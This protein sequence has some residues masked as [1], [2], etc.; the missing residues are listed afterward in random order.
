MRRT[1]PLRRVRRGATARPTHPTRPAGQRTPQTT[2]RRGCRPPADLAPCAKDPRFDASAGGRQPGLPTPPA[3]PANEHPRPQPV[4]AADPRQTWPLAP[5]IPAA[6]RPPGGRQPGPPIPIFRTS[7]RTNRTTP[8]RGCRPPT[9]LAPCAEDPRCD[10][11]T[12]GRQP[13]PRIPLLQIWLR[14]ERLVR[15]GQS[16][17][18]RR[19]AGNCPCRAPP[20]RRLPLQ[21]PAPSPGYAHHSREPQL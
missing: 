4:G 6:T 18:G 11:S 8:R 20:Q 16:P 9:D 2:T 13:G 17:L 12:G 21:D 7:P 5:K 10:A 15:G 3:P 19:P 1:S 14:S